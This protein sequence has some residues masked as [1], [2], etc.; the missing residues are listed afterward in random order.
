MP[1]PSPTPRP[2]GPAGQTPR[3]PAAPIPAGGHTPAEKGIYKYLPIEC[4]NC[5]FQGKVNISRLDQ[6]FHC[7][8]CNQVFHVTRD[9][10]M[11]GERPAEAVSVDHSAA[12]VEEQPT[13]MERH[14]ARLPPAAKWS[15]LGVL[16]LLLVLGM[17][18]LF[19]PV[20]PLPG[21]LGD[22][23][24]V[25]GKAFAK[26]DWSTLKRLAASGTA[27]KLGEWYDKQRPAEWNED[28]EKL[29]V[30]LAGVRKQLLR[31]EK[32]TPIMAVQTK[33]QVSVPDGPVSEVDLLWSETETGEFWL[34][35]D[36]MRKESKV[37]KKKAVSPPPVGEEA[38][39]EETKAE[40]APAE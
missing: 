18:K 36:R 29:D 19:E 28:P 15:V 32:T 35:G 6:T 14:F 9:G 39:S 17:V 20:E 1:D 3:G 30:K 34:E 24:L 12:P 31:Y 33:I 25:A 5:G 38:Q 10:T 23:A 8:Q 37:V 7:K 27:G 11:T 22:R 26:G 4:P 16:A 13:W 21:E 40:G 2:K